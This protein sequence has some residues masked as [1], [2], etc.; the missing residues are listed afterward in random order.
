MGLCSIQIARGVLIEESPKLFTQADDFLARK[1]PLEADRVHFSGK[2]DPQRSQGALERSHLVSQGLEPVV[3]LGFK[4]VRLR[5]IHLHT[6]DEKVLLYQKTGI[7]SIRRKPLPSRK[8]IQASKKGYV[9]TALIEERQ[10]L[11]AQL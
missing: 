1:L 2:V 7:V 6:L 9:L 5:D 3:V 10:D 11:V 8:G 4:A